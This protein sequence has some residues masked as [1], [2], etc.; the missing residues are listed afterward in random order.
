MVVLERHKTK[1]P[2]EP[3]GRKKEMTKKDK[4]QAMDKCTPIINAAKKAMEKASDAMLDAGLA[5]DSYALYKMILKL[6]AMQNK[7]D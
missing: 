4:A 3:A 5:D 6:E 1:E 2:E 7:Y